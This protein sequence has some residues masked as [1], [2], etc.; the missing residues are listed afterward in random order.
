MNIVEQ[1]I[2]TIAQLCLLHKVEKLYVFGSLLTNRYNTGSD[3]D[4]LV[5]F[6]NVDLFSYFDNYLE[7]KEGLEKLFNQSVDLVEDQTVKNPIL[8]R[9]ID[10]NKKLIYGRAS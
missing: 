5:S 2:K 9:S 7:M 1:N 6:G 10:R 4:L 8:R 3:I